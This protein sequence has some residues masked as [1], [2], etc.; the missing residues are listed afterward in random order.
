[1]IAIYKYRVVDIDMLHTELPFKQVPLLRIDG[2]SLV[3]SR[4][5]VSYIGRKHNLFGASDL[6]KTRSINYIFLTALIW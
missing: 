6:E 3:Q 2:L 5:I 4:A 1:M